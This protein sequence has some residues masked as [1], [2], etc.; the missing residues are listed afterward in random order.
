MFAKRKTVVLLELVGAT[1]TSRPQNRD[2]V[3]CMRTR[4][5][6]WVAAINPRNLQ[7][8]FTKR[9][10]ISLHSGSR[11]AF[12]AVKQT[13]C[14]ASG[15]STLEEKIAALL[16]MHPNLAVKFNFSQSRS[17]SSES[18]KECDERLTPTYIYIY[19][20][21]AL[22]PVGSTSLSSLNHVQNART[23]AR[24]LSI[25]SYTCRCR[26][27]TDPPV[28]IQ[29]RE[30]STKQGS[31]LSIR[32]RASLFKLDMQ[33]PLLQATEADRADNG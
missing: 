2:L 3:S 29:Q 23:C 28:P 31:G 13:P 1:I 24:A 5:A 32:R 11:R 7:S 21:S 8:S 27:T 30:K 20:L 26:L 14:G 12:H 33:R 15:S 10:P 18:V 17:S 16:R 9:F 4:P 22:G 6:A 25:D 19:M